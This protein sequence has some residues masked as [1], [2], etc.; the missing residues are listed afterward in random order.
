MDW[1]KVRARQ[2]ADVVTQEISDELL[3]YD[4]ASSSAI[5]LNGSATRVWVLC[6]GTKTAD[7]IAEVLASDIGVETAFLLEDV[8]L[9]LD[10]LHRHGLLESAS[11]ETES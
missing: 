9:A 2:R 8:S 1:N 11:T 3:V 7:E 5:S 6:D 4:P 10:E